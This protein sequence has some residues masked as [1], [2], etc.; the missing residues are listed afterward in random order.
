MTITQ[1]GGVIGGVIGGFSRMANF[2]LNK[3]PKTNIPTKF[4][5]SIRDVNVTHDYSGPNIEMMPA[6]QFP[7]KQYFWY[8]GMKCSS[9]TLSNEAAEPIMHLVP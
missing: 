4:D 9:T 6:V 5:A 2:F 8:P 7:A 3:Y 1:I